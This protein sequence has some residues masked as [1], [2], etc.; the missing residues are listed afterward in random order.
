MAL[1]ARRA[2]SLGSFT[3][4]ILSVQLDILDLPR[5]FTA[6]SALPPTFK[7]AALVVN[8]QF[9]KINLCPFVVRR[10]VRLI[11]LVYKS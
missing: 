6:F 10:E 1:N 5:L 9:F 11:V 8:Q 7:Q 2:L 4:F 3:Q